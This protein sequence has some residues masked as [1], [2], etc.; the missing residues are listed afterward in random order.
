[1]EGVLTAVRAYGAGPVAKTAGKKALVVEGGGMRGVFAAGVLD[2]FLRERFNPFDILIGVSSGAIT[3]ASYMSGQEKR[4]YRITTGPMSANGFVSLRRF[5][6]GGHL[7]D[8]DGLWEYAAKHDPLDSAAATSHAGKEYL[9]GVTD[10]ETA[11]PRFLRPDKETL[12]HFL[13]A[14]CALPVVCRGFA[15]VDGRP[16]TDGGVSD[17]IPVREAYDRGARHISV[18][19]TRA[20]HATKKGYL[21][22][23]L[24]SLVFL[25]GHPLLQAR[26]RALRHRYREAVRFIHE[27]PADALT[28]EIAPPD[29]LRGTRLSSDR[30]SIDADYG[31]GILAGVEYLRR[32]AR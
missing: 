20:P 16:V 28:V 31:L 13:K 25:G 4:Y 1:M 22:D 14:S 21:L 19:R 6:R 3:L 24:L 2:A 11:E 9:V 29:G 18:I 12:S 32:F 8:L 26:I 30:Q 10:V 7:M 5:L 15:R 27:P 23:C 17:P